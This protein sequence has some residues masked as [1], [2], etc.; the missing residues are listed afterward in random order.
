MAEPQ[1]HPN[2]QLKGSVPGPSGTLPTFLAHT[3]ETKK[4]ISLRLVTGK[5]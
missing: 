3:L 1:Q 2:S 5:G 4:F